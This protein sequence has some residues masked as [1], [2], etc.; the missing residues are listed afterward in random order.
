MGYVAKLT[1]GSRTLDLS[2]G[3]Y[4]LGMDFTPPV[5]DLGIYTSGGTS[6][7]RYGGAAKVGEKATNTI[8]VFSVKISGSSNAEVE[9]G[10]QNISAFLRMA[11]DQNEPL[12]FEWRPDNN[13]S[14]EPLWGQLGANK[15]LQVEWGR[16]EVWSNYMVA[17]TRSELVFALI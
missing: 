15:R 17:N 3:R 2:S 14:F 10:I 4:A 5:S 13:V 12:Y 1:K 7:N 8:V 16:A 11:G 9:H 6:A